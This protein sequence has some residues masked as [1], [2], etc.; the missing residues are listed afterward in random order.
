[1]QVPDLI[2]QAIAAQGSL[3]N[4]ARSTGIPKQHLS[5]YRHGHRHAPPAHV[6]LIA[7]AAGL[8]GARALLEYVAE[9]SEGMSYSGKLRQILGKGLIAV[10]GLIAAAGPEGVESAGFDRLTKST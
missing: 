4:L 3:S 6:A 8:P 10:V 1:M 2:E 5:N 7:D 9:E